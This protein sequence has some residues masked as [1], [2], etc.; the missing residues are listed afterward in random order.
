M[1]LNSASS[2]A[3]SRNAVVEVYRQAVTTI[4]EAR[5]PNT[6]PWVLSLFL[7]RAAN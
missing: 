6:E 1:H 3:P 5:L 4:T 2:W 7:A